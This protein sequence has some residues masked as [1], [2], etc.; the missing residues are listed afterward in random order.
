M[1]G[2][3]DTHK[4]ELEVL[5]QKLSQNQMQYYQ[6][7]INPCSNS[8]RAKTSRNS[9]PTS[10]PRKIE[11]ADDN[12]AIDDLHDQLRQEGGDPGWLR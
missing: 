6:T 9:L 2:R 4:R 3:L 7:L 12:K 11:I 1:K 8:I 5:Q 10:T